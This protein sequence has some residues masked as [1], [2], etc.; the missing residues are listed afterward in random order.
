MSAFTPFYWEQEKETLAGQKYLVRL[1]DFVLKDDEGKGEAVMYSY[2]Y[3]GLPE[4]KKKPV[5]FAYNGGPGSASEWL[6]MGLLGPK[7]MEIPGYPK[8][9]RPAKY[10]F[11]ENE[12]FLL[13]CCDLVLIDPV[14]TG[15]APLLCEEAAGKY[16]STKGDAVS[17][18]KFIE[19]SLC[20]NERVGAPVYLLG[21]SYGT[22]R[23]VVLADELPET[24]NLRGIISVGTSLNVGAKGTMLVEPNVRRLG[25]NA[26]VCRYHY[27]QE[28]EEDGFVREAMEFAYGDYAHALLMGNRLSPEKRA[29]V[30]EKLAYYSGLDKE[31]LDRQNLRFDEVDFM[32]KL[33]PGE[34]VSM[35][36]ARM[37]LP[38]E[39]KKSVSNLENAD[40][41]EVDFNQEPFISCIGSSIGDC[42]ENY[43][44]KELARPEGRTY[45]SD[46]M[47]I[48]MNWDYAGYDKDT[49][50]LPVDLMKEREDLRILFVNGR[51]DLSSTFDFVTYYLSQYDLPKDRI[52]VQVL[53]SGHASYIG[54]GNAAALSKAVRQFIKNDRY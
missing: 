22:I 36:D 42:M 16:Y 11:G 13:D 23:N 32:T 43:Y 24:I 41:V 29:E 48:A 9:E 28:L 49:L 8:V 3:M 14:G 40:I 31:L 17:F 45:Q 20:Q 33:R 21:E 12:E 50:Q 34:F 38:L 7:I 53:E 18:A 19:D 35:Y 47:P 6:H 10:T 46:T 26:A 2:T 25:V 4:D 37:T 39:E 1:A 27:H 54:D 5:V 44:E 51:Y 15:Y 52:D 30:L